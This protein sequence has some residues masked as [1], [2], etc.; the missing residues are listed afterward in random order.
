MNNKGKQKFYYMI[1]RKLVRK[2]NAEKSKYT[3]VHQHQNAG[4]NYDR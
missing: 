1:V 4:E 2:L 3:L